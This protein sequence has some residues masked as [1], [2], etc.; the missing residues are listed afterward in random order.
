MVRREQLPY[1]IQLLDDD[2]PG[3]REQIVGELTAFG[4][5]LEAE[6][7]ALG[8]RVSI[9]QRRQAL[10]VVARQREIE[11]RWRVWRAWPHFDDER[12]QLE[13]ALDLLSQFQFGWTP[14][15]RIGALLDDLAAQYRRACETR[16]AISLSRFLFQTVGLGGN[17]EQYY[18]PRNSNLVHVIQS[19]KGLPI[20]LSCVFMLVGARCG[21]EIIGC[22]VPGHF[23][24]RATVEKRC[25]YFDCFDGGRLLT[26]REMNL[27]RLRLG[28]E[29]VPTLM[30]RATASDIVRRVLNNLINAYQ[31]AEELDGLR[32]MR[33]LYAEMLKQFEKRRP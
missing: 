16:D 21:I 32:L 14:P 7:D 23:L 28:P 33:S 10:A 25:V 29:L 19:G 26:D 12:R 1:L 31:L 15:A 24:T 8:D 27:L 17:V 6:L 13:T 20:S 3:V 4:P 18:D 2:S 9:A 5:A 22:N 30:N 11:A